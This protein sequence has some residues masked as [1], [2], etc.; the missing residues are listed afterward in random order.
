MPKEY[1]YMLINPYIE[2]D[3]NK[4]FSATTPISAAKEAWQT[5]STYFAGKLDK[6]HI[7]LERVANNSYHHF[8]VKEKKKKNGI[9]DYTIDS[10]VTNLD[11]STLSRFRQNLEDAQAKGMIYKKKHDAK[12]QKGGNKYKKSRYDDDS[13]SDDD[14]EYYKNYRHKK[15]YSEQPIVYMW[16]DPSIYG[17]D[18]ILFPS[19]ISPLFFP[20]ELS[21]SFM[22]VIGNGS[23]LGG[24]ILPRVG[25]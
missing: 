1:H 21:L 22:P 4:L 8:R 6:F 7:T 20:T 10:H 19:L 18:K 2:G 15:I 24:I 3:V 11:T 9:I 17:T 16:Y 23:G 5:I 14:D 25:Q 12:S 13:S